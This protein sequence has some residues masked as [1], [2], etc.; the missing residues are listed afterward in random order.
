MI[1]SVGYNEW[2]GK[3]MCPLRLL[4]PVSHNTTEDCECTGIPCPAWHGETNEC[5][6]EDVLGMIGTKAERI[7]KMPQDTVEPRVREFAR[8]ALSYRFAPNRPVLRVAIR[9]FMQ[10]IGANRL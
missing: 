7:L 10:S 2:D 9:E 4:E 1:K 8:V 6:P 5:H 3:L